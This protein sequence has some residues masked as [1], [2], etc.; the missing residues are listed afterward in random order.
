MNRSKI[1]QTRGRRKNKIVRKINENW[2][3]REKQ[4]DVNEKK[5][6]IKCLAIKVRSSDAKENIISKVLLAFPHV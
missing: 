3:N 2:Q 5:P 6:E 4:K 1:I